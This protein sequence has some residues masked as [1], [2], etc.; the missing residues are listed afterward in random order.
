M[1]IGTADRRKIAPPTRACAAH[2]VP[3]VIGHRQQGR[4]VAG[5]KPPP[6]KDKV[7][8]P[9]ANTL[10][11]R[12]FAIVNACGWAAAQAHKRALPGSAKKSI[13]PTG[14]WRPEILPSSIAT[15][16]PFFGRATLGGQRV[17]AEVLPK[18]SVEPGDLEILGVVDEEK[19][20]RKFT[21]PAGGGTK[22]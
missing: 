4:P 7:P 10:A 9:F 22:P 12:Y 2:N 6:P 3:I 14:F 19:D 5:E 1:T 18:G 11:S 21:T 20:G 16:G 13:R 17:P 15:G 8:H